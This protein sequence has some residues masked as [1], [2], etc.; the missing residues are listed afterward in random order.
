MQLHDRVAPVIRGHF[1][2][3]VLSR[4]LF[5]I[6]EGHNGW[7]RR[8]HRDYYKHAH[9]K[10]ESTNINV[11]TN[12]IFIIQQVKIIQECVSYKLLLDI[13]Y[14]CTNQRRFLV[15]YNLWSL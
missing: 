13:P 3:L 15:K 4:F 11:H 2:P 7:D 9:F 14:L 8:K 10:K 12:I 6:F 1:E 5:V